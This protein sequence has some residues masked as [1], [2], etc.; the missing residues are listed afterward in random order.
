MED[1]LKAIGLIFVAVFIVLFFSF[2]FAWFIMLL[3]NWLIPVIFGLKVITFWQAFGLS[4]LS[5]LL[6]KSYNFNNKKD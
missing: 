5:G 6:F 1:F 3:W 2:I 4:L